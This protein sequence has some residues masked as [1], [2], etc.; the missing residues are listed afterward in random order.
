[1]R[2]ALVPAKLGA[3]AKRRL[4]PGLD[5]AARRALARAMLV[6]VLDALLRAPSLDGVAVVGR[7]TALAELAT[8]MGAVAFPERR[9]RSLNGAVAEGLRA[10]TARGATSV[11]VAMADLPLLR[12]RDVES[13]LAGRSGDAV[14]AAVSRD[15]TGTNLLLLHPPR[16][17][18][19]AFGPGSLELHRA[20]ASRAGVPFVVRSLAGPALD[21]DTPS[22]LAALRASRTLRGETRRAIE[23]V[24]ATSSAPSASRNSRGRPS[25]PSSR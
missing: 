17:I 1:M 4:A 21:V 23:A 25:P 19:T 18:S 24:A 6:D 8:A 7:G 12:A 15:G 5:V 3:D 11:L 2:W 10:C 16:V 9:A 13:M 22:D 14:V 20:A